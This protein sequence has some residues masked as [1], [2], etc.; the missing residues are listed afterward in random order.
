MLEC[1]T[2]RD[3]R[4]SE[5][6][7]RELEVTDSCEVVSSGSEFEDPVDCLS[8]SVSQLTKKSNR[9]HPT[10]DLLDALS[11]SLADLVTAMAGGPPVNG[12][13]ALRR[14]LRHVGCCVA[15]AEIP[16]ELP[17]V[18]ALVCSDGDLMDARD[19]LDHLHGHLSLGSSCRQARLRIGYQA[20]GVLRQDVSRV[21]ELRAAVIAL[22]VQ[23]R[24][25]IGLR[26]VRLV[27][28]LLTAKVHARVAGIIVSR[29]FPRSLNRLKALLAGP[30]LQQRA[31]NSE[32]LLGHQA[33]PL[34]FLDDLCQKF[35]GDIPSKEAVP[36]LAERRGVP[37]RVVH[38]QPYKPPK[39]QVVIELLHQ[40][41]LAPNRVQ[42]LNQQG[43][44]QLLRRY[45]RPAYLR[46]QL[47][48]QRR[49]LLEDPVHDLADAPKRVV[50]RN[51]FLR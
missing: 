13:P 14:V 42:H 8:P 51:T 9:L 48:E 30:R 36:V 31:I 43:S 41:A 17:R 3:R 49:K 26:A 21:G 47:L 11:L 4:A 50:P 29:P 1:H 18:V 38:R 12:A 25:R 15:I 32:V 45:R 40:H 20:I 39:Q 35:T 19:A 6:L 24:I 28:A 23:A 2:A 37:H 22:A 10:E 7:R 16:D 44:E 27:A 5:S 33:S 46:I 34:S